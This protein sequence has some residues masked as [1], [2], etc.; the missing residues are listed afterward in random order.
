MILS[1]RRGM[2]KEQIITAALIFLGLSA[3]VMLGK[4]LAWTLAG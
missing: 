2:Q 1:K 4:W 3:M